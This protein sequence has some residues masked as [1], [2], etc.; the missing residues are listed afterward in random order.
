MLGPL[1]QRDNLP[2]IAEERRPFRRELDGTGGAPEQNGVQLLFQG[3]DLLGY[4]GLGDVQLL[5]RAKLNVSA[6]AKKQES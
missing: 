5:R 6:T 2:G 1:C 4:G 3:M